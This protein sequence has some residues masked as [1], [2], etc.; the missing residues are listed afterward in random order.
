MKTYSHDQI[1]LLSTQEMKDLFYHKRVL[2]DIQNNGLKSGFV[3]II[4]VASNNPDLPVG[5]K[6]DNMESINLFDINTIEIL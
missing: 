5:I 1:V 2:V 6:I 3:T 4:E